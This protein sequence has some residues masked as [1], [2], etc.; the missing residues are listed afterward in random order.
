[1]LLEP[2]F[3]SVMISSANR[4]SYH[5]VGPALLP[6]DESQSEPVAPYI[7]A[8]LGNEFCR[9]RAIGNRV[10]EVVELLAKL[11]PGFPLVDRIELVG[12]LLKFV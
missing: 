9:Q 1:M 5:T 4:V 8:K 6:T 12:D 2:G 3:R 7:G 10:Q 11:K